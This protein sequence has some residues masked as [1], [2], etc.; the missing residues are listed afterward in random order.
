MKPVST[1][2]NGVHD[3]PEVWSGPEPKPFHGKVW[4]K[5]VTPTRTKYVLRFPVQ[6]LLEFVNTQCQLGCCAF[7]RFRTKYVDTDKWVWDF[8]CQF[9]AARQQLQTAGALVQRDV[10]PRLVSSCHQTCEVCGL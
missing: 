4:E 2:G 3:E 10:Q 5:K 9:G 7:V 8:C 1:G 6:Q